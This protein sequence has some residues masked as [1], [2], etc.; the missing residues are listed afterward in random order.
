MSVPRPSG[1]GRHGEGFEPGEPRADRHVGDMPRRQ[2]RDRLRHRGD[3][4]RGR[5][6]AAAE[7]VDSAMIGPLAHGHSHWLRTLLIFTQFVVTA[8][9]WA[10]NPPLVGERGECTYERP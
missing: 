9:S 2:P 4:R 8:A 5:T 6:A 1:G 10:G 7:D 3:M